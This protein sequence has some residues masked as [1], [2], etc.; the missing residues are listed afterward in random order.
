MLRALGAS[1]IM[2][3]ALGLHAQG[4][5]FFEDFQS[6]TA[7]QFPDGSGYPAGVS[8]SRNTGTS[9][10]V[11][12]VG[13]ETTPQDPFGRP[14]NQS[15]MLYR[16]SASQP[17]PQATF[18]TPQMAV[19]EISYKIWIESTTPAAQRTI[20]LNL[21]NSTVSGGS[22]WNALQMRLIGGTLRLTDGSGTVQTS[23]PISV[24]QEVT[25]RLLFSENTYSVY[26]NDALVTIDGKTVFQFANSVGFVDTFQFA[27]GWNDARNT[28]RFYVDDLSIS[29]IPE[30][31]SAGVLAGV[32]L[33]VIVG[34][35]R[36]RK[37]TAR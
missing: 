29:M 31:A 15:L 3:S 13:N 14:G 22:A 10:E 8:A 20:D 19:G 23:N 24:E 16:A 25:V 1:V 18:S 9:G 4:F 21:G 2:M 34:I 12:V 11:F 35:V 32:A 6:T 36:Y 7:G 33:L 17:G 30:G 28:A 27:S 26:F 5:T 37:I